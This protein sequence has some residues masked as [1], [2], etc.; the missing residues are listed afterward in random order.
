MP[1]AQVATTSPTPAGPRRIVVLATLDTKGQEAAFVGDCIR[2]RHHE[3]W[4]VDL[5]L[6]GTPPFPADT[7]RE[8]VAA[9]AGLGWDELTALVRTDAM[10]A[11]AA[12][13]AT[14]VGE[15]VR[16]GAA[17]AVIGIGG[18]SGAWLCNAIMADLPLGFP[19][20][21][22][23]TRA[24]GDGRTDITRMPSVADI[25][26]VNSI[27][28]PILANAAA[29]I[30]GMAEGISVTY[31]R[32]CPTVG[33]TMFGVTTRGGTVVREALEAAGYEVIVFHTTGAGG[34]TMESLTRAGRFAAILDWTTTE[35]AQEL[36]G[37]N[38]RSG[39]DRLEAPG[40]MG[41]P[42][43]V[44]PGAVDV[45]NIPGAIP[46]KW[47]HRTIHMHLPT[48]PLM[49]TNAEESRAVGAVMAAK[50]NKA[51]GPVRVLIPG[52]GFSAVDIEGGPFWDPEAD[53]AFV[54]ELRAG[55]RADIP[56][57]IRDEHIN[58]EA[59]ARAAAATLIAMGI[60]PNH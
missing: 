29:A 60:A 56:L 1:L 3:P 40:E 36:V 25:S 14:I 2:Q 39:P 47:A 53:A 51:N 17:H 59:F 4:F 28:G 23:S 33:M 24:G 7:T 49:R 9:A 58:D 46:E 45:N 21:V 41:I 35:V 19:K 55:L 12:G 13:A 54:S 38:N 34:A 18:G 31:D 22:V 16:S 43:L 6:A 20:L 48:V 42:H 30:C 57:E 37:A 50:L 11:A 32:S 27:L 15:M 5:S 44:V 10:V 52:R 26:G 8:A